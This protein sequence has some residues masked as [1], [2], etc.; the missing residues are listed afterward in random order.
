[1]RKLINISGLYGLLSLL[2]GIFYREF[3]KFNGFEGE[4]LL[5]LIHVHAMVL[6]AFLFLILALF[7]KDT[8]LIE[9]KN[10]KKFNFIYNIGFPLMLL[11]LY[12]KG[13]TQVLQIELFKE[14]LG[15]ISGI[16]GISHILISLALVYLF[17]ALRNLSIIKNIS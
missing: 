4:T 7:A 10:F 9:N 5:S 12:V 2:S 15:S 3:T 1:M 16:S 6:G 14:L 11:I 13:I 8:N 17:I